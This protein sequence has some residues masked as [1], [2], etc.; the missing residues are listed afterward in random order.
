LVAV[1]GIATWQTFGERVRRAIGRVDASTL[2]LNDT[3]PAG[4]P[5]DELSGMGASSA[6]GGSVTVAPAP[7]AGGHTNSGSKPAST[8]GLGAGVIKYGSPGKG[9]FTS[10]RVIVI[11]PI[12]KSSGKTTAQ[13]L[14]HEAGHATNPVPL[15]G[16][17]GLTRAQ[18]IQKDVDASLMDE[19]GAVLN[20]LEARDQIQASGGPDIGING[21]QRKKYQK[22][23]SDYKASKITRAQA[24]QQ[25]AQIW[26]AN[27]TTSNTG[28]NYRKYYEKFYTRQWNQKFPGRPKTFVAP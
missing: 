19:A 4:A 13:L 18:Y 22:I 3:D 1:I 12:A 6:P 25:I 16:M 10:N 24:Q 8:S 5:T 15:V 11:D 27:E 17:S 20:N 21:S 14:A 7:A 2:A 23:Y 28:Q 26:G 9:T